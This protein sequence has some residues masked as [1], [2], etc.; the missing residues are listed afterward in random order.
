MDL[1]LANIEVAASIIDPLFLRSPQYED[2]SLNAVL[3][4]RVLLK[5]ETANPLRSFKGR[6]SDYRMSQL[7]PGT[8]AVCASAGNFGQALAFAGRKRGVRVTVFVPAA[9]NPV[10]L[11]RIEA[12]GAE[13]RV[14]GE[15]FDAAKRLAVRHAAADTARVFVEDGADAAI[16]EGAGTISIELLKDG[17]FDAVLVPVGD[18]ALI[19]GMALWLR[20]HAPHVRVIGVCASGAAAMADSFQAR[21][22][23]TV[24]HVDTIADGLAVGEPVPLAVERLIALV[25]E[26]LAVDDAAMLAAM[27]LAARTLGLVLEP[28]GAAGLAALATHRIDGTRIATVLT[29]S[30]VHPKLLK[31]LSMAPP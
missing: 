23:V 2:E 8:E 21:R 5:V 24:R 17:A 13:V 9:V 22:P 27:R 26:M 10:K 4:K 18:G 20:A 11:A 25:D 29:G 31:T 7:R 15:D 19:S 16:S 3:G 1:S 12:F 14:G 28:S 6:G 30:N